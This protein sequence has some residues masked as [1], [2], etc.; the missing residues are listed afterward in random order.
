LMVNFSVTTLGKTYPYERCLACYEAKKEQQ[1]RLPS[2]D[3]ANERLRLL[4]REFDQAGVIYKE[5]F[6][7]S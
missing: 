5:R 4:Y 1:E 3:I 6:F 7:D 2:M